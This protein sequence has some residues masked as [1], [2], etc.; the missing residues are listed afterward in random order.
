[1]LHVCGEQKAYENELGSTA[2][3]ILH[4]PAIMQHR[5]WLVQLQTLELVCKYSGAA[6]RCVDSVC[7][8]ALLAGVRSKN[9]RVARRASFLLVKFCKQHKAVIAPQV[10]PFVNELSSCLAITPGQAER[11]YQNNLYEAVGTLLSHDVDDQ[12]MTLLAVLAQFSTVLDRGGP[13][14]VAVPP[15]GTT[16]DCLYNRLMLALASLAKAIEKCSVGLEAW[17][18][19]LGKLRVHFAHV[20]ID[21]VIRQSMILL[22]RQ[23]LQTLPSERLAPVLND[24]LPVVKANSTSQSS[25]MAEFLGFVSH[26]ITQADAELGRGLVSSQLPSLITD[27]APAWQAMPVDSPE[28]RREK[29]ELGVAILTLMRDSAT[30]QTEAFVEVLRGTPAVLGL[31]RLCIG[32]PS[33]V[34]LYTASVQIVSRLVEATSRATDP[35]FIR[36]MLADLLNLQELLPICVGALRQLNVN[37]YESVKAVFLVSQMLRNVGLTQKALPPDSQARVQSVLQSTL[38][39]SLA[40][41]PELARFYEGVVNGTLPPTQLRETLLQC[42][43][44]TIAKLGGQA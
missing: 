21:R 5:S 44:I 1:M 32:T 13:D 15:G 6:S 35:E 29:L 24:V 17:D 28:T 36:V 7:L 37:D 3:Q 10:G 31:I 22:C 11:E 33:E 34:Q 42:V 2:A 12:V 18:M 25:D 38:G 23:L 26:L 41:S 9:P 20:A 8:P 30:K 27:L 14:L 43:K 40:E 16:A 19:V 39:S 4:C